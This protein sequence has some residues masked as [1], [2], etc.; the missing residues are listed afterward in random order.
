MTTETAERTGAPASWLVLSL[1]TAAAIVLRVIGLNSGLW[2][3]EIITLVESARLPLAEI[4]TRFPGNN[5]HTLFSVLGHLSIQA[6]GEHAWSLRLPAALLGAATV[7]VLYGLARR[8]TNRREAVLACVLLATSYHHVWFSQNARGYSALAFL[9]LLCTSLLLR[10]L[11][12]KTMG[13]AAAYAVAAA[14]GVY[15]H[16]TFVFVVVSHAI[17]VGVSLAWPRPP[18]APRVTRA[19]WQTAAMAFALAGVF[20]L[21]LYAPVLLDVQQFFVEGP[22]ETAVATPRWAALELLRGLQI[23]LGAGIGA[24]AAATLLVAGLWSYIRQSW[25]IAALF[26]LPGVV[27]V[28]GAVALQRPIFPRFLFFLIG[29]G[30]LIIVR[31]ASETGAWL[32]GKRGPVLA[33]ALV[34]AIAAISL[35]SL[36][37]NY[38]YPKQDFEG[39]LRFVESSRR[40]GDA[41][42]TA[43][44]T[45]TV[46]RD[47]FGRAF[48][49]V[50]TLEAFTTLRSRADRVWV[51]YTLEGYIA[52]QT[53]DLMGA[54]RAEC[55]AV[56]V[57]RGTVGSGDVIVCV[58]STRQKEEGR[59]RK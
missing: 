32:A 55:P 22:R 14:L 9:T 38:R 7:P 41:I 58:A 51:L 50:K 56:R 28:A 33:T 43:G 1:L 8:V 20:T 30:L 18:A 12:R 42:A 15:A 59:S 35:Y 24:I 44:L 4:V 53:P 2:Y 3:D 46:Y 17:S 25:L 23:G 13:A 47:Y 45:S 29:F 52:S 6:F 27:T 11:E 5:Q 31:G 48:D 40:E 39:A 19:Q 54:L 26:V 57:F 34:A 16:L 37:P 21:A 49:D 36:I 10:T